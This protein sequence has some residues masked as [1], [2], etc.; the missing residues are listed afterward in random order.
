MSQ[1]HIEKTPQSTGVDKEEVRRRMLEEAKRIRV[2]RPDGVY[3]Y[4]KD[5]EH[6]SGWAKKLDNLEEKYKDMP[7]IAF[8]S[9]DDAGN[10]KHM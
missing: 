7:K 3:E 2:R 4:N 6:K 1:E 9:L 5:I 10:L 8:H